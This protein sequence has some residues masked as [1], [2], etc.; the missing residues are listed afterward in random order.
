MD[1]DD[2]D[3]DRDGDIVDYGVGYYNVFFDDD[4]NLVDDPGFLCRDHCKPFAA[5][6]WPAQVKI[7]MISFSN[8]MITMMICISI[9]Y[10]EI[11]NNTSTNPKTTYKKRY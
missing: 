10:K 1:Y 7:I 4:K 3:G 11:Q 9:K 8:S 5:Q 6:K 2:D